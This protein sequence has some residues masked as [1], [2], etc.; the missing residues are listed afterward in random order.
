MT[1]TKQRTKKAAAVSEEI[2]IQ[3]VA[4]KDKEALKQLFEAYHKRIFRFAYKLTSDREAASDVTSDVFITIWE[5]ANRFKGQSSLS[6]WIFGITRNKIRALYRKKL[7]F[8]D[9]ERASLSNDTSNSIHLREDLKDALQHLSLEHREAVEM[10]FY[11]GFSYKEA[12]K[13]IGCPVGTVKSRIFHAKKLLEH[14]L[15]LDQRSYAS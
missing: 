12:A 10:I 2:L 3:A 8:V 1:L 15:T 6:T 7:H 11:L 9:M 13:I 14:Y 5:K 4:R